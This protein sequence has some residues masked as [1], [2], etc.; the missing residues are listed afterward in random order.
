MKKIN[1]LL[2]EYAVLK[3]DI[4]L[5]KL[6]RSIHLKEHIKISKAFLHKLRLYIRDYIFE[7]ITDEIHFFKLI[8]PKISGELMFYNAQLSYIICKPDSTISFQK[9]FLK[10]KL[11]KLESYK[12]KNIHFYRYYKQGEDFLDDKCFLRGNEQLELFN[13]QTLLCS[14]P[15]FFTSHDMKAATI[16]SNDLLR[17]FYKKELEA[18]TTINNHAFYDDFKNPIE[19]NLTWTASKTDLIELIYALKYSGAI[20]A[21]AVQVKEITQVLESVFD[22]NLGNFYKTYSEIKS[23]TKDRAKFLNKL[24]ENLIS[25]IEQED[26]I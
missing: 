20:N 9:S 17:G 3:N 24:S 25:K 6:E 21:G 16:I 12:K 8:K 19:N 18:L 5:Q 14:D 26:S 7:S 23:R 2:N 13:S 1:Y 10:S 15:E 11:K 4:D 22:I